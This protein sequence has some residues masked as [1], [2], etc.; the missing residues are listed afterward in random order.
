MHEWYTKVISNQNGHIYDVTDQR[1]YPLNDHYIIELK[2]ELKTG[3]YT[4]LLRWNNDFSENK[5]I[6]RIVSHDIS[7]ND[8]YFFIGAKNLSTARNLFPCWDKPIF[9]AN[10]E[11][12]IEHPKNFTALSNMP[13][14]RNFTTPKD[15]Y[16]TY[17]QKTPLLSPHSISF[18]IT[19]YPVIATKLKTL[20]MY[21]IKQN[22]AS[23][24]NYAINL[25]SILRALFNYM[26]IFYPLPKIDSV[27]ISGNEDGC[28][29]NPG[30]IFYRSYE[31][32]STSKSP[33]VLYRNQEFGDLKTI[34]AITLQ[35]FTDLVTPNDSNYFWLYNG[36][37]HNLAAKIHDQIHPKLRRR[38]MQALELYNYLLDPEFKKL[39]S[40]SLL[41]VGNQTYVSENVKQYVRGASIMQMLEYVVF[42]PEFYRNSLQQY[43][44]KN[45]FKTTTLEDLWTSLEN[46]QKNNSRMS[47][48]VK[49]T[50]DC[51]IKQPGY[52][53]IN[54]TRNYHTGSVKITRVNSINKSNCAWII[55]LNFA[56]QSKSDFS[57]NNF[58]LLM[59]DDEMTFYPPDLGSNEWIILNIQQLGY[60][61]VFYDDKN[62]NFIIN[63]LNSE[64]Y[65][66]IH[67]IN[68][69][70]IIAE[71][72]ELYRKND[73]YL[74]KLFK[75]LWYLRQEK[76]HLPLM[77]AI[78][79]LNTILNLMNIN[80]G[81]LNDFISKILS[82][83]IT[84]LNYEYEN[85]KYFYYTAS[86]RLNFLRIYCPINQNDEK[87]KIIASDI[88]KRVLKNRKEEQ[89][90]VKYY[91]WV[92]CTVMRDFDETEA[93]DF[94]SLKFLL[95]RNNNLEKYMYLH[96]IKN[97]TLVKEY[98]PKI[99]NSDQITSSDQFLKFV[100]SFMLDHKFSGNIEFILD[101]F[102]E[103]YS[104]ILK[105]FTDSERMIPK[106]IIRL[107]CF[108]GGINQ[109][110]KLKEFILSRGSEFNYRYLIF[111]N[112]IIQDLMNRQ[113]ENLLRNIQYSQLLTVIMSR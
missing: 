104:E 34:T 2:E 16:L 81:I 19:N 56:I 57:L 10:F 11:I 95:F 50:V 52:P 75:L 53:I 13:I 49:V 59:H 12:S 3:N 25:N 65:H 21:S 54:V 109:W 85:G 100:D 6:F 45:L 62:W 41:S 82:P 1:W 83:I 60:Y 99:M 94:F 86:L 103:N 24:L 43:L 111:K 89:Y 66:K 106:L 102:I 87:C 44:S 101:Y 37:G 90:F 113:S 40:I 63:Y 47:L 20:S 112:D 46:A 93:N 36:I 91:S 18:A 69:A 26:R 70:V 39:S 30:L 58:M 64:N 35:W 72:E 48:N 15:N 17:F 42:K 22:Q 84:F 74:S 28:I 38:E 4:L 67:P 14:E 29:S 77:K 9:R 55:P 33:L 108:I 97:H 92:L 23:F 96:C 32:L 61:R 51:W 105:K 88:Y 73:G 110:E 79:P 76:D 5:E 8:S 27:I 80:R 107:S 68:R 71:I 78:R 31:Y 7:S 98:F